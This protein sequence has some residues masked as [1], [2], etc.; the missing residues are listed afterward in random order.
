[1]SMG[2]ARGEPTLTV[3]QLGRELTEILGHAYPSVWVSGEIQKIRSRGPHLYFELAEKGRGDDVVAKL[4]VVLFASDRRRVEAMLRHTGQEMAEGQSLRVRGRVDYYAPFGKLQLIARDVDAV[5]S[6]GM[7]EKR[8]RETLR[9]LQENELLD[10]NKE[11]E[12]S[13]A[14]LSVGLVTSPGSAADA[15]F[16][17]TL[18]Q[19]GFAFRVVRAGVR[20]QGQGAEAAI[21]RGVRVLSERSVDDPFDCLVIIR[22]G[23]SRTDLAAFDGR[24]LAVAI[25]ECPVPVLTGIGHEVDDVVADRVAYRAFKTPTGAGEFLAQR[26]ASA[27]REVLLAWES[28]EEV[29]RERLAAAS[30][31]LGNARS[32]VVGARSRLEKSGQSVDDLGRRLNLVGRSRI[33]RERERLAGRAA[34]LSGPARRVLR[35]ARLKEKRYSGALSVAASRRLARASERLEPLARLCFELSPDRILAR[36]FSITRGA[37]GHALLDASEVAPGEAVSIT[38]ARG[39]L[40]ATV[41]DREPVANGEGEEA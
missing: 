4:D 1:M 20:V 34:R 11:R 5:F 41:G 24:S 18:E 9:W 36:G 33:R 30:A 27:E 12:L 2:P 37:A 21:C 7:L 40:S 29:A 8:R 10:R 16:L 31:R 38:L 14:P 25:A 3:S 13:L 32:V 39:S 26:M 15:D 23:G 28:L 22:G 35:D 19:S 17:R 6:L